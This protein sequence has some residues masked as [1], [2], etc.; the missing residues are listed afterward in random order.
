MTAKKTHWRVY[1]PSD[2]IGS[3]DLIEAG[4]DKMDITIETVEYKEVKAQEGKKDNCVVAKLVGQKP[5]ILNVTNC[6]MMQK[7][8][9][10]EF[11]EDWAG[12]TVTVSVE[13]VHAFGEWVDCLRIKPDKPTAAKTKT[14]PV[15]TVAAK[16]LPELTEDHDRYDEAVESLKGG[17]VTVKGI[18]KSF[19]LSKEMKEKLETI[20][21]EALEEGSG[22]EEAPKEEKKVAKT[23]KEITP[24]NIP[25]I[26]EEEETPAEEEETEEAEAEE[27]D[28]LEVLTPKHEKWKGIKKAIDG[29]LVSVDSIKKQYSISEEDEVLLT[30]PDKK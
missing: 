17:K 14:P 8:S 3:A 26:E 5:M 22:E 27:S 16:T 2:Y 1:H 25:K 13:K 19:S 11:V 4:V 10:S 20:V 24:K 30:T 29:E 12:V 7:V 21:E 15:K 28:G 18:K 23:V 6:K 9:G